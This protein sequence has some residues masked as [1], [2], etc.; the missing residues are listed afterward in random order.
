MSHILIS[1]LVPGKTVHTHTMLTKLSVATVTFHKIAY[2]LHSAWCTPSIVVQQY[3]VTGLDKMCC[4][5]RNAAV[6]SSMCP[7]RWSPCTLQFPV[8]A[9]GPSEGP[10]PLLERWHHTNHLL[11]QQPQVQSDGVPLVGC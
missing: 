11:V 3:D 6:L 7:A 1:V 9:L 5:F 4:H 2:F 10:S 8:P